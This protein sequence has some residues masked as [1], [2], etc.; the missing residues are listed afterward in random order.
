MG[1]AIAAHLSSFPVSGLRSMGGGDCVEKWK[2]SL[3][4]DKNQRL[5]CE[6][7]KVVWVG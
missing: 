4:S 2:S 7:E 3:V 6:K 1:L 5:E